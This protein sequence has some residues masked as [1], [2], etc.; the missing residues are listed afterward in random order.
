MKKSII[1]YLLAITFALGALVLVAGNAA[2]ENPAEQR[3]VI[4]LEA[5]EADYVCSS[6]GIGSTSCS[7][8]VGG[9]ASGGS[10]SFGCS[11]TCSS[12]YY[13]CCN[14]WHNKCQC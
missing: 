11:V 12:G 5:G 7:T 9:G 8:S 10:G 3:D 14:A 6:G 13:A 4:E 2:A 1:K